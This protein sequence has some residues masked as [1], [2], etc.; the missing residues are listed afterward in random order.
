M[1]PGVID[2]DTVVLLMA[3]AGHLFF[4]SRKWGRVEALLEELREAKKAQA[5]KLDEHTRMIAAH[6]EA[7]A[8]LK[9]R[10]SEG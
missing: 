10:F 5:E 3:L 7:I 9:E 2:R 6:D 1:N 8:T 4:I